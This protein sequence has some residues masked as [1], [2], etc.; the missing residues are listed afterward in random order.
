M[1]RDNEINYQDMV[2]EEF[3]EIGKLEEENRSLTEVMN[4]KEKERLALFNMIIAEA[5]G[6]SPTNAIGKGPVYKEKK[7]EYDKVS[8]EIEKLRERNDKTIES[9]LERIAELKEKRDGK[10]EEGFVATSEYDGFLA[11]L[12][13]L[14]SLSARNRNIYFANVFILILFIILES[15]PVLVKLLSKRGPYDVLLDSEEMTKTFDTE[16]R[17]L[18][19]NSSL[20]D[21]II[22]RKQKKRLKNEARGQ[23]LDHY[24]HQL[25]EAGKEMNQVKIDSWK[26]KE[27]KKISSNFEDEAQNI[28]KTLN[29]Q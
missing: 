24:Y 17:I 27:T 19:M 5:E 7:L 23:V 11:R 20:D 14:G 3:D 16:N 15:S 12:E 8:A 26:E 1:K 22:S 18:K 28:S 4:N 29:A 2:F 13:A 9:N 25:V 21:E 10:V 6:R